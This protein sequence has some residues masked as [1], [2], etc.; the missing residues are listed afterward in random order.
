[1]KVKDTKL[2]Y[3]LL[4]LLYDHNEEHIGSCFSTLDV[5]D[6]IYTEKSPDDIVIL[7][8]G[9]AA[10][11]LYVILEKYENIDADYLAKKHLGH[12]NRDIEDNIYCSTGSL[13]QGI[14]VGVGAAL[15]S[16]DKKIYITISDGECSEGSVW[17]SLAF[18]HK[19]N[20]TNIEVTAI[21]N[22][23]AGYE[24]V[25]RDYLKKR[26]KSFLPNIVIH[27]VNG[28][29]ISFIKDL[30]AHYMKLDEKMY[31]TALKELDKKL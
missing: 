1:M 3:R 16:P 20:L 15:A 22:G 4:K 8:N 14:T 6:R 23:Y 13:G 9:H 11:A 29:E 2:V 17:E 26:L 31:K 18:I 24:T 30:E 7:S 10:Y 21:V 27:E 5:L 12:P 19:M 28:Y 25:D